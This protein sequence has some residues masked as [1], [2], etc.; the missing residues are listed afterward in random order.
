M[1]EVLS[2]EVERKTN[3]VEQPQINA[4][5]IQEVKKTKAMKVLPLIMF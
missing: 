3:N 4:T 1:S 2:L 5:Q